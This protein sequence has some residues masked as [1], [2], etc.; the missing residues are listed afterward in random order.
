MLRRPAKTETE[1]PKR[2]PFTYVH[3]G[4]VIVGELQAEG[5]VRVHGTVRG[6]VSVR[7]VL[8]VAESGVVEGS[9]VEAEEVKVLGRV[10]ANVRASGKV[11]IWKGGHLVGDVR[12]RALDI[13]EGAFFTGRS[14][15]VG[16]DGKVIA[17]PGPAA[18]HTATKVTRDVAAL[19][20]QDREAG[21]EPSGPSAV[22]RG[23]GD[24]FEH[25][26][27]SGSGAA[28]DSE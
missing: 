26:M 8:E 28:R 15:M 5:R 25:R 2:E 22:E 17:L 20:S 14:E 1:P 9:L 24:S 21:F 27:E 7:G 10:V 3:R 6:V 11:E 12:A 23:A 16:E 13:E 18:V 4:T 19:P